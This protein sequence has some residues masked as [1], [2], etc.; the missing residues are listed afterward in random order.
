[1]ATAPEIYTQE[2]LDNLIRAA[3]DPTSLPY[4]NT[5][6]SG[7]PQV[8]DK[9]TIG[10]FINYPA[11]S[12][13]KQLHNQRGGQLGPLTG[14]RDVTVNWTIKPV[15]DESRL[16]AMRCLYLWVLDKP[17]ENIQLCDRTV[18]RFF[19][20]EKGRQRLCLAAIPKGWFQW[21]RRHDIP[22]EAR[23]VVD[24]HGTYGWVVP[25][26]E[27]ELTR[28]SLTILRIATNAKRTKTVV[29]TYYNDEGR[30]A[31][32]ETST[33][34]V[35]RIIP[36]GST[37]LTSEDLD[38]KIEELVSVAN[39]ILK[40]PNY[41]SSI[42]QNLQDFMRKLSDQ[43]EADTPGSPEGANHLACLQDVDVLNSL[44]DTIKDSLSASAQ[45]RA[46][47][48]QQGAVQRKPS[49]KMLVKLRNLRDLLQ[50]LGDSKILN[51]GDDADLTIDSLPFD[52]TPG[53]V[54]APHG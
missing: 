41:A 18:G 49:E 40:D 3:L 37:V 31:Q 14:E 47:Q 16:R 30:I 52:V 43:R 45:P 11:Q 26:R 1:M 51:E 25:G 28:F 20:D 2:I 15:N 6:D 35:D 34:R 17:L 9:G 19:T 48:D 44:I 12:I 13:V 33:E 7:V 5:L 36:A 39:D 54:T 46:G 8:T 22:K 4:F 38:K 10:G 23:Y 24:H 29:R 27:E 53:L 42:P 32:Q 50:E 21:G